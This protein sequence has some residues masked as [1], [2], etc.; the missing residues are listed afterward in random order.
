MPDKDE[1]KQPKKLS[2]EKVDKYLQEKT[3]TGAALAL[4]ETEKIFSLVLSKLGYPGKSTDEKVKSAKPFI[5]NLKD[6][7]LAR[8]IYKKITDEVNAGIS[9]GDIQ[10]V[11]NAYYQAIRDLTHEAKKKKNV[12]QKLKLRLRYLI[13][14]PKR[15]AKK[16]AIWFF[17]FFFIVFLLDTTSFGRGI[18][19][20]LVTISHFIFS[21]ILWTVLILLGLAIVILGALFFFSKR[22]K[23]RQKIRVEE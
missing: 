23:S 1:P 6:L 13:P 22:K 12:W 18:V 8:N 2:W 3:D 17:G 14:R 21:W 11:L 5:K 19:E 16:L 15:F 7:K 20:V 4:I 10:S 9:S